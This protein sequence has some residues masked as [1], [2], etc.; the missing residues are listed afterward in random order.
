MIFHDKKLIYIHVPKTGGTSIENYLNGSVVDS[1]Y[2]DRDKCS[3]YCPERHCWLQHLPMSEMLSNNGYCGQD[4]KSYFSFGFVRNPYDRVVSS[5]L[6]SKAQIKRRATGIVSLFRDLSSGLFEFPSVEHLDRDFYLGQYPDLANAY[7]DSKTFDI[8]NHFNM[9]GI[10][11]GRIH[12]DLSKLWKDSSN[13]LHKA[14]AET[15]SYIDS[16]SLVDFLEKNKCYKNF[17]NKN[18]LLK[19]DWD[20]SDH[21]HTQSYFLTNSE[22]KQIVDFIGRFE[23]INKDFSTVGGQLGLDFKTLPKD[24]V[25]KGRLSYQ[26]Y[27]NY[28]SRALTSQIYL[29]DIERFEYNY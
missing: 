8:I 18:N 15:F 17:S 20:L 9:N 24:N 6:W 21:F 10:K 25:S 26:N 11:E 4:L 22:G 29:C 23:N 3:G 2:L 27:H 16:L 28:H 13:P 14:V 7:A 1:N 5:W 12:C 19:K